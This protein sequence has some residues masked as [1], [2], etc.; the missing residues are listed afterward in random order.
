M[1][2]SSSVNSE[3]KKEKEEESEYVEKFGR[4]I[5]EVTPI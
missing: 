5:K 2:I 1:K 4:E 3:K